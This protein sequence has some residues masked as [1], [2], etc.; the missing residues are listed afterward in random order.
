M[1]PEKELELLIARTVNEAVRR[2]LEGAEERWLTKA[3]LMEQFA[4]FTPA[5]MKK[6]G[7]FLP[8]KSGMVI[9][10]NG[11]QHFTRDAYPM[12]KINRMI[13]NNELVFNVAEFR[14][15]NHK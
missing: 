11:V 6:Y 12:H 7:K 10:E 5:W 4:M 9:D 15:S 3:Q 1:K 14:T 2:A 8:S 13:Q